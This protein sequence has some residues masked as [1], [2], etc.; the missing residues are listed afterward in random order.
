MR[1]GINIK[2]IYE[3]IGSQDGYR[4]LVDRLWPSGLIKEKGL[5][6]E[7]GVEIRMSL[8]AGIP[9]APNTKANSFTMNH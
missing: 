7:W 9:L 8:N 3:E 1:P 5:I 2:R 6:N 4:I